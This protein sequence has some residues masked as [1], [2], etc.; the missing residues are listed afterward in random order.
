[1]EMPS[2]ARRRLGR[3]DWARAALDAIAE[4]GTAAVAVEPLAI[5][6]GATKGSFYWHF[7]G[8]DDL[9]AAAIE[10]WERECTDDVIAVMEAE[11]DPVVRLR[12]LFGQVVDPAGRD[13]AE[14]AL[15][16][17]AGDPVAGPA[18][19]RVT[20]RRIGY[21]TGLLEELGV[22]PGQARSR[23]LIAY[24]S[25]L[26]HAQLFQVSPGEL[27]GDADAWR[28]HLDHCVALLTAP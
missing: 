4:G 21:V 20:A 25:Y 15:L 19:R 11:P 9:V 1:M 7:C 5:R 10:L 14:L 6:L 18:L 26:G 8:R 24:T 16:I 12:R 22:A 28:A 17:A 3:D 23:A 13:R 27:P 2:Q